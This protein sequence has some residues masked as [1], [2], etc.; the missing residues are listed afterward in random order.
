MIGPRYGQW[1][2]YVPSQVSGANL[3]Y[4]DLWNGSDRDITVSSLTAVKETAVAVTGLVSVRL[5]LTRTS[6]VGTGGTANTTDGSSLTACT[7]S[8]LQQRA[9]D[10]AITARLTPTGGATAGA[11]ICER[12]VMPEELGSSANYEP[13]EFLPALLT[14]PEG[15][16]IRV[17]QG[18]VASVGNIGFGVIFY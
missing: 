3:V 10:T 9:C 17:V 7:I 12:N 18:S 13:L 14:V 2:V 15:T 16:G 11:V 5:F 8:K 1:M 4:F 6:A